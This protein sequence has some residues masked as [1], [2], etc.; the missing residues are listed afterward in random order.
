MSQLARATAGGDAVTPPTARAVAVRLM[1]VAITSPVAAVAAGA[2][3]VGLVSVGGAAG[4]DR[5]RDLGLL[6]LELGVVLH[7]GLLVAV[8][9]FGADV[10]EGGCA[11][12]LD[13]GSEEGHGLVAKCGLSGI[14]WRRRERERLVCCGRGLNCLAD[15]VDVLVLE[16]G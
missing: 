14:W 16:L 4:A 12:E 3:A 10:E 11:A 6:L 7:A 13:C 8:Q 15:G 2:V 9:G 5:P 1:Q